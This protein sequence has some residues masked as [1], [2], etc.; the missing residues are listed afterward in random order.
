MH[1]KGTFNRQT[2]SA[3][4]EVSCF[5]RKFSGGTDFKTAQLLLMNLVKFK[6]AKSS[7]KKRFL[8]DK[9][10]KKIDFMN[11]LSLIGSC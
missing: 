3:K 9:V 1:P 11:K 6:I 10:I 5:L 7:A 8:L 2:I 4:V